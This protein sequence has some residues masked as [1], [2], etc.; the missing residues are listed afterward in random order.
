MAYAD[1]FWPAAS[2]FSTAAAMLSRGVKVL[3]MLGWQKGYLKDSDPGE[4]GRFMLFNPRQ[5]FSSAYVNS[6]QR[7][8]FV[9]FDMTLKNSTIPLRKIALEVKTALKSG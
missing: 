1:I 7:H 6:T 2:F 5:P 3:N 4:Q 8:V 9:D